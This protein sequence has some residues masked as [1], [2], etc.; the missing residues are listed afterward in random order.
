MAGHDFRTQMQ[1]HLLIRMLA[2]LVL[3]LG[4]PVTLLLRSLPRPHG[5]RLSAALRTRPAHVLAHPVLVLAL[6]LGGLSVLYRTPVYQRI[7]E[8]PALHHP[9]HVH[10]P[11]RRRGLCVGGRRPRPRAGAAE[12]AA[13]AR[14]VA[15]TS[16]GAV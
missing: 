16:G 2:P 8:H 1:Q 4:A 13:A 9:V 15:A 12:R 5:R 10:F 6:N 14:E 11:A 3:V 7:M